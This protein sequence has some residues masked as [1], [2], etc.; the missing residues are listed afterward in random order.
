[1]KGHIFK[2]LLSITL[3]LSMMLSFI[4]SVSA[5]GE[6][7]DEEL[8]ASLLSYA[9]EY[10]NGG[11]AFRQSQI[12][13]YED[14]GSLYVDVVRLGSFEGNASVTVKAVDVSAVY[15][16]DYTLSVE[17]GMFL[18][19]ELEQDNDAVPLMEIYA[20]MDT[21]A[22]IGEVADDADDEGAVINMVIDAEKGIIS[23]E[24]ELTEDPSEIIEEIDES[25]EE[26]FTDVVIEEEEA[27]EDE[28]DSEE[29]F[30]DES[31]PEEKISKRAGGLRGARA[32]Y[33]G[34]ESDRKTWQETTGYI[35]DPEAEEFSKEIAEHSGYAD[36]FVRQLP[37]TE[38]TLKFKNGEYIKRI[39]VKLIDDTISET[40]E[41]V[42]FALYD[43]EGAELALPSTAYLNII[44]DDENEA[45][46]FS[47]VEDSTIVTPNDGYAYVKVSRISGIEKFASVTIATGAIDAEPDK[48]YKAGSVDVIFPQGVTE[49]SVRVPIYDGNRT[50]AVSFVM[51]IDTETAYAESGRR[52]TTVTILPDYSASSMELYSLKLNE[53]YQSAAK[54]D[55][56]ENQETDIPDTY[57]EVYYLGRSDASLFDSFTESPSMNITVN[58]QN[59][60]TGWGGEVTVLSGLDLRNATQVKVTY[61]TGGSYTN[62]YQ[63]KDG[64]DTKTRTETKSGRAL[65]LVS[66]S[67]VTELQNESGGSININF[68]K[69]T[70]QS[71]KAKVRRKDDANGGGTVWYKI[72]KV[73]ITYNHISVTVD[74]A[75]YDNINRYTER[76]YKAGGDK[77]DEENLN[78]AFDEGNTIMLGEGK[79]GGSTSKADVKKFSEDVTFSVESASKNNTTTAGVE[80]KIGTNVYHAGWQVKTSKNEYDETIPPDQ[81]TMEKLYSKYGNQTSYTIRPVF[82]PYASALQFTNGYSKELAYTNNISNGSEIGVT[83]LDTITIEGVAV[84]NSGYAVEHFSVSGYYDSGVHSKV[85]SANKMRDDAADP[86]K[87][88][89]YLKAHGNGIDEVTVSA[90]VADTSRITIMPNREA[91]YVG[92]SYTKPKIEVMYNPSGAAPEKYKNVGSVFYWDTNNPENSVAGNAEKP[93]TIQPVTIGQPVTINAAYNDEP[94]DEEAATEQ[95]S[96]D[97]VET[98]ESERPKYKIKWQD[99]TGDDGDGELKLSESAPLAGYELDRTP[100]VGD[101]FTY[102]PKVTNSLIYYIFEERQEARDSGYI[103]GVVA[104]RDYP[105]FGTKKE[106]IT[107]INGAA[108]TV[109]GISVATSHDP[110]YGGLEGEGGD[111]YFEIRDNTFIVGDTHRVNV[112]YGPLSMAAVQAVNAD[113]LQILDAYDTIS[114]RSATVAKGGNVL[115]LTKNVMYNDD[116][117]YTLTFQTASSNSAIIAAKAK[118]TFYRRD[119]SYI[120]EKEYDS[121]E[122]NNG[123]FKCTFNPKNIDGK[124]SQIPAGGKITVTFIDNNGVSYFEHDTGITLMQSLGAISLLTSFSG[125]AAP[126]LQ[127]IGTV[128]SSFG[129]GWDGNLDDQEAEIG[130]VG[131]YSISTTPEKKVLNLSLEFSKD[132]KI[133]D[134][135]DEKDDSG[136]KSKDDVK[137]A[138]QGTS[139]EEKKEAAKAAD[140]GDN[141]SSGELAAG[142]KLEL[143]FGLILT[144]AASQDPEHLGEWYFEEFMIVVNAGAEISAKKTFVTPIG[145]PVIV[146]GKVGANG[147]AIIVVERQLGSPEYYMADLT[148]ESSGSVDLISS[149]SDKYSDYM[150][151]YGDFVIAPYI[152]LLAGVGPDQFSVSV[153]GQ[154]DFTFNFGFGKSKKSS[155]S[156]KFSGKLNIKILIFKHSWSLGQSGEISLFDQGSALGESLGDFEMSQ[157]EYLSNRTA[158]NGESTG[159][160]AVSNL[161]ERMLMDGVN[162]NTDTK[163]MDLGGDRYIAVFVDDVLERSDSNSTA[164]YYTIYDGGSWSAP[165]IIEDDGTL[166]DSPAVYDIGNGKLFI[167]WSTANEVF[168][169]EPHMLDVLNSRNIHGVFFDKEE[170]AIDGDVIEITKNTDEDYAGDY[171]AQIA[172]DEETGRM[173]IYYTKSEYEASSDDEEGLYG[174]A[175][176]PYSLIAYTIYDTNTNE[177]VPYSDKEEAAIREELDLDDESYAKYLEDYYNQRFL[178][179]APRVIV[180]ETLDDQGYWVEEPSI[181]EYS[182]ESDPL[183]IESDAISYNGLALY[184]YVLDYDGS[185]ETTNDRDIFLQIYN[186]EEDSVTHS[187]MLT[188]DDSEEGS[189]RFERIGGVYTYLTYLSDGEIKMF[190]ITGN[191]SDD[192]VMVKAET[193]SGEPYYYLDKSRREIDEDGNIPGY[194]PVITVVSAEGN[195]DYTGEVQITDF[196]LRS[197]ENYFYVMFTERTRKLREGVDP[198]SSEAALPENNLVETQIYMMRYDLENGEFTAPVQVTSSEGANYANVAFAV[199]DN[200]GGFIALATRSESGI[201]VDEISYNGDGRFASANSENSALYA[202]TF[203][204]DASVELRNAYIDEVK[205]GTDVFASVEVYNGGIETIEGLTVE[206]TDENGNELIAN[207]GS[208]DEEARSI[209]LLGGHCYLVSFAIPVAETEASAI[210]K[211]TVKDKDGNEL[212]T[213]EYS[214][215]AA[216]IVDVAGFDI[217]IKERGVLSF[218]AVLW[219]KAMVESGVNTFAVSCGDEVIYQT[220]IASIKPDDTAEISGE[221]E[222]DYEKIFESVVNDDGS[223]RADALL[224]ASAGGGAL[225][226]TVSLIASSEQMAR[227]NAVRDVTFASNNVKVRVDEVFDLDAD[228]KAGEYNGRFIDNNEDEIGAQGVTIEY[229]SA[230]EN[231]AKVYQNGYIKG[232]SKGKTTITAYLMPARNVYDGL[233]YRSN[234]PTLP[235][236]AIRTYTINVEVSSASSNKKTG[237]MGGSV[238]PQEEETTAADEPTQ[239]EDHTFFKDVSEKDWFYDAVKFASDNGIMVGVS[240]DE[241]APYTN[242]TRAMFVSI[243]YRM[244]DEHAA[245]K[246]IFDDVPLDTWYSEAVAWGAANKIVMGISE[247]EFAPDRIITREQMC[248]MLKRYM[249]HKSVKLEEVNKGVKFTDSDK[250][251]P[252]ALEAVNEMARCGIISGHDTGAFEPLNGATR[253]ECAAV[254]M[255]FMNLY[256]EVSENE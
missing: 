22:E 82:Y 39:K 86:N 184:A 96:T 142:Y 251:S 99:F 156:V 130:S 1:M 3:A 131:K 48:D 231:I 155:G 253:A 50:E 32:V 30:E 163:L 119:G 136:K 191:I 179:L 73:E 33:T 215:K 34:E 80:A 158:W 14:E 148:S 111:G 124:G 176:Y 185:K 127:V 51:A 246:K 54:G 143:S 236:E 188:A 66:G 182:G 157:R 217:R 7:D 123:I 153:E 62:S 218:D 219:N 46:V 47:M 110:Q 207:Y 175:V 74:S 29:A 154:A 196:D 56:D 198:E 132:G 117:D 206:I 232:I 116:A 67:G 112:V 223:V 6:I 37:G 211:A 106:T 222:V 114:I 183:V 233:G 212:D 189:L 173:L 84:N 107:P 192:S 118:L 190:D 228:I 103:G 70:N 193:E 161:D 216:R 72:T 194:R 181:T 102:L 204:P 256:R 49:R 44:D 42:M 45:V 160:F 150:Y 88:S 120:T 75:A 147:Q 71:I 17:E 240:D 170:A 41:Q 255:R 58:S 178:S 239:P 81:F 9:E 104:L 133:G 186:F 12:E 87:R 141:K 24:P 227:F 23:A 165:R 79:V 97:V 162:P 214:K 100:S 36:E 201:D 2:K 8:I 137:K 35:S 135:D 52:A 225:N 210:F 151:V 200:D 31:E 247:T 108:V 249:D 254:V 202:I 122:T 40:D 171:D 229:T 93:M 244:S 241:F 78:M 15:G 220:E 115:D 242:I 63:Y 98:E 252:Y 60:G 91:I 113:Y 144:L 209:R 43:E 145:I 18:T 19:R 169:E 230:D 174:D 77:I 166:D 149:G 197:S 238:L 172:Y 61:Q 85:D 187:I 205:S 128:A 28:I 245:A 129:F 89:A 55:A 208:I 26:D 195:G 16:K 53:A 213:I 203:A 140:K 64:C 180:S 101:V 92:M 126:V 57:T 243:L 121:T 224:T 83:M 250:I 164:V 94:S 76:V 235:D 68:T 13:A 109:D 90:N 11:F 234:Y 168:G 167:A 152:G 21:D 4:P 138:A 146:G 159:L 248:A 199:K 5:Y 177:F 125:K 105:V 27:S 221:F 20:N 95:D 38:Y 139:A 237:G 65:Q 10:P 134:K 226:K 25:Y 69:G 59:Y